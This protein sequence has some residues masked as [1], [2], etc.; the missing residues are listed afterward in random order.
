MDVL[1]AAED[2]NLAVREHDARPARIL[3][4]KLGLPGLAGDPADGAREVLA[5]QRLDVADLKGLDVEVVE[6]EEGDGVVDVEAERDGAE[7][8]VALLEGFGRGV[9]CV[10]FGDD[11]FGWGWGWVLVW[12]WI[13]IWVWVLVVVVVVVV[14]AGCA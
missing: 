3:N 14:V 1:E 5:V 7:E 13:W 10:V 6:P 9:G 12:I 2:V 11:G 8:V 4:R